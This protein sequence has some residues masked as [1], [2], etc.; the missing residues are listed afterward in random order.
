MLVTTLWILW[1]SVSVAC[2]Y[3]KKTRSSNDLQ[4]TDPEDFP[5]HLRTIRQL[6]WSSENANERTCVE[7][8]S[9]PVRKKRGS[10][11]LRPDIRFLQS[12]ELPFWPDDESE[13]FFMNC[14]LQFWSY[15]SEAHWKVLIGWI[16]GANHG[17]AY[18]LINWDEERAVNIVR[19]LRRR[20][21]EAILA[22]NVGPKYLAHIFKYVVESELP[23]LDEGCLRILLRFLIKDGQDMSFQFQFQFPH[24]V[25]KFN[26]LVCEWHDFIADL[27]SIKLFQRYIITEEG[28]FR[29]YL[30]KDFYSID[31]T[32][33]LFRQEG[34]LVDGAQPFTFY[35][36]SFYSTQLYG[37]LPPKSVKVLFAW[38]TGVFDVSNLFVPSMWRLDRLNFYLSGLTITDCGLL[39]NT[40][41]DSL[42]ILAWF[43]PFF[44][45]KTID[46]VTRCIIVNMDRL[47]ARFRSGIGEIDF[48][49]GYYP[50]KLLRKFSDL[51]L[52]CNASS[53]IPMMYARMDRAGCH[54]ADPLIEDDSLGLFDLCEK[55][56]T[57]VEIFRKKKTVILGKAPF[58]PKTLTGYLKTLMKVS[59][60]EHIAMLVKWIKSLPADEQSLIFKNIDGKCFKWKRN[61]KVVLLL[62]HFLDRCD[63]SI[64]VG[65][66]LS[67]TQY[68]DLFIHVGGSE[69]DQFGFELFLD[70]PE[71]WYQVESN[72]MYAL[73]FV[74]GQYYDFRS[75]P[76]GVLVLIAKYYNSN[77]FDGSFSSWVSMCNEI[78]GTYI[79]RHIEQMEMEIREAM[80]RL[81]LKE[82]EQLIGKC[83]R[84]L[85]K[86]KRRQIR[87]RKLVAS[88][89]NIIS[90]WPDESILPKCHEICKCCRTVML[91]IYDLCSD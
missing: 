16:G 17:D 8:V 59:D 67:S 61:D 31:E 1:F 86:I 51:W 36:L 69:D 85:R 77:G 52:E 91:E 79:E 6:R 53:I 68:Y 46:L 9:S 88:F 22:T 63:P 3:F 76:V 18:G 37:K 10:D 90:R 48:V 78:T 20:Q 14:A 34:I 75:V 29:T 30:P 56:S 39:F 70:F 55:P 23:A 74:I 71:E 47:L 54:P 12:L 50:L 5:F 27:L 84:C 42:D 83:R 13:P 49:N 4:Q 32:I 62:S 35:S 58:I 21:L 89:P 25:C 28:A 24:L 40:V 66:G 44:N 81:P 73:I 64:F 43:F 15:L 2:S 7:N 87:L 19:K 57:I 41:D 72:G 45:I 65:S 80:S 38:F 26:R 33:H 60:E 82:A 11:F